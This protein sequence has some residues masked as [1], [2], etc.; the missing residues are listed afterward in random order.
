MF[1][2]C[3]LSLYDSTISCN[4]SSPS[5][6][7]DVLTSLRASLK[8]DWFEFQIRRDRV[9]EDLLK[10]TKK[11]SFDPLKQIRVRL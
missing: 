3:E 8:T 11:L 7:T 5:S 2:K 4:N 1:T 9:L 6:L 10:D